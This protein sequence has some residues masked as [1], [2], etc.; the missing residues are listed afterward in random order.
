MHDCWHQN[1][2][3]RPTFEQVVLRLKT[4]RR[5]AISRTNSTAIPTRTSTSSDALR[6]PGEVTPSGPSDDV[7]ALQSQTSGSHAAAAAGGGDGGNS[8]IPSASRESLHA[9]AMAAEAALPSLQGL[10]AGPL[11]SSSA[12]T[13]SSGARGGGGVKFTLCPAD[14]ERLL[15]GG[16]TA[17]AEGDVADALSVVQSTAAAAAA[18]ELSLAQQGDVDGGSGLDKAYSGVTLQV[19]GGRG[20]VHDADVDADVAEGQVKNNTVKAAPAVVAPV[21]GASSHQQQRSGGDTSGGNGRSNKPKK[22]WSK[23]LSGRT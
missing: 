14:P 22:S 17:T 5:V 19:G 9:P 18:V 20:M 16:V 8:R 15:S 6:S 23:F 1:P 3:E 2:T 4:L 7:L 10:A 12:E 13:D 21:V 11:R